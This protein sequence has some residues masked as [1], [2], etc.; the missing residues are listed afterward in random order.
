MTP[1]RKMQGLGNDFVVFDARLVP[2]VLTPEQARRLAD[3]HFGVGCDTV[4]VILPGSAQADASL[5]FFNADGGEVESCGNAARCVAKL[6]MAETGKD[7]VKI[8][9]LGGPLFCTDAG[10]GCS[11]LAMPNCS[12]AA[13]FDF[14]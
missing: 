4:V 10:G 14:T 3:R 8:D 13:I 9:T 6:L 2:V 12:H 11:Q 5:R 7:A 1:F